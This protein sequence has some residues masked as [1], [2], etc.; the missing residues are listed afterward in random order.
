MQAKFKID[1]I[2]ST[3]L[4]LD[5]A[6]FGE[7]QVEWPSINMMVPQASYPLAAVYNPSNGYTYRTRYNDSILVTDSNNNTVA[8][9]AGANVS[10]SSGIYN[11]FN[12]TVYFSAYTNQIIAI[13]D[14]TLTLIPTPG[15][16]NYGVFCPVNSCIYFSNQEFGATRLYKIDS[17]NNL[18][19]VPFAGT[20]NG[21]LFGSMGAYHPVSNRIY[22]TANATNEIYGIDCATDN[23]DTTLATVSRAFE[24]IY[25][26]S[27]ESIYFSSNDNHV[28]T[29]SKTN[30]INTIALPAGEQAS[31]GA[32]SPAENRLYFASDTLKTNVYSIDPLN[33]IT[34]IPTDNPTRI[35]YN[36]IDQNVYLSTTYGLS[37]LRNNQVTD[38]VSTDHSL[39]YPV[40][41]TLKGTMSF[42]TTSPYRIFI[43]QKTF[44]NISSNETL[45]MINSEVNSG[46]YK[47]TEMKMISTDPNQFTYPMK[48]MKRSMTGRATEE[49]LFPI[50]HFGSF[51]FQNVVQFREKDLDHFVAGE[52]NSIRMT[53]KANSRLSLIFDGRMHKPGD[54]LKN[55]KK[56]EYYD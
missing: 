44:L 40:L 38:K 18:T 25:F 5:F 28:Y 1:I 12:Q 35:I 24:G 17:L 27:N 39:L 9:L 56:I 47:I 14:L 42:S 23:F 13:K 22:F 45:S 26:P 8:Q 33:N 49:P 2:N 43:Y 16:P 32:Y 6:L 11:P 41:D 3:S 15:T 54:I 19:F 30:S 36:S 31:Y 29:I 7:E 50:D 37:T 21:N 34:I 46:G 52:Q 53:I 48:L 20:P 55:K 10:G 51:F 4:D